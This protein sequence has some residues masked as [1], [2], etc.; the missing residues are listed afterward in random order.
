MISDEMQ[1]RLYCNLMPHNPITG[2]EIACDGRWH[3]WYNPD[4]SDGCPSTRKF[5]IPDLDEDDL[6]DEIAKYMGFLDHRSGDD[7][8]VRMLMDWFTTEDLLFY[9]I[10]YDENETWMLSYHHPQKDIRVKA[11]PGRFYRRF[12]SDRHQVVDG[13]AIVEM[14]RQFSEDWAGAVEHSQDKHLEYD[15][16]VYK[17]PRGIEDEY[18]A[19][20]GTRL[21]SCMS[22]PNSEFSTGGIHPTTCYGS[23]SQIHLATVYNIET[24]ERI[25]RTLLY[26]GKW[27]RLYPA[28]DT[29]TKRLAAAVLKLRGIATGQRDLLG[30]RLNYVAHGEESDLIVC[31]YV[32]GMSGCVR[33]IYPEGMPD[34]KPLYILVTD[35]SGTIDTQSSDFYRHACFDPNNMEAYSTEFDFTCHHCGTSFNEHGDQIS[36]DDYMFCDSDCAS[37]SGYEYAYISENGYQGWTC[38]EVYEWNGEFYTDEALEYRDLCVLP[39]GDVYKRDECT[40]TERG[41]Y[42]NDD[43]VF[44]NT[45]AEFNKIARDNPRIFDMVWIHP[46]DNEGF[47]LFR[48]TDNGAMPNA[49]HVGYLKEYYA[50]DNLKDDFEALLAVRDSQP[51]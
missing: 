19:Y 51:F 24:G 38:D 36:T 7:F 47:F 17:T 49:K 15:V 28:N 9:Q 35:G 29:L 25:A 48:H 10:A 30:A 3:D 22:H 42:C 16:T 6:I 46:D 40:M 23:D 2:A 1:E 33:P 13:D 21:N 39:S 20:H 41:F 4:A 26:N 31:P 50:E 45:V 5:I 34:G 12:Q 37:Q 32:D 14:A 44:I 27:V 11:R 43:L 8:F 18:R